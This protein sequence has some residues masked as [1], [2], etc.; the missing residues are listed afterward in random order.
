MLK[1]EKMTSEEF[2]FISVPTWT[3]SGIYSGVMK[4]YALYSSCFPWRIL[5]PFKWALTEKVKIIKR[6]W[7]YNYYWWTKNTIHVR[8]D[9]FLM[10]V[11]PTYWAWGTFHCIVTMVMK[12]RFPHLYHLQNW[13][14]I[15]PHP[16][17]DLLEKP[18]QMLWS[19]PCGDIVNTSTTAVL[20]AD[21]LWDKT[22]RTDRW[23]HF[24]PFGQQVA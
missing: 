3:L 11:R 13:V 18:E 24:F 12:T 22:H 16:S 17:Q 4:K 6:D 9:P 2:I 23:G 21:I 8:Q 15:V 19:H 20:E 14:G 5:L 1:A 10:C 7:R